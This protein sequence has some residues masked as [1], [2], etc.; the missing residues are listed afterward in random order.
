[1]PREVLEDPE[2]LE[3]AGTQPS[4]KNIERV[5]DVEIEIVVRFGAASMPLRSVVQLGVG[6]M[7]ELDRGVDEPVELLVNGRQFACGEVVV[8]D[9]YHGVRITEIGTQAE[10][11][12]SIA[13]D[14]T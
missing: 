13:G 2:M 1:L 12:L 14:Q 7:V 6:S 8:V 4:H 9:G 3:P 11:S 5:L 10:R